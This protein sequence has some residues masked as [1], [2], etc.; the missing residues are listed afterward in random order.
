MKD[1]TLEVCLLPV[2]SFLWWENEHVMQIPVM[3]FQG[4]GFKKGTISEVIAY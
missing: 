4:C 2:N 3:E 1:F